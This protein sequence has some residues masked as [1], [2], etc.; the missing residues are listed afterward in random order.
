M[1]VGG[2]RQAEREGE[3]CPESLEKIRNL[4]GAVKDLKSSGEGGGGLEPFGQHPLPYKR[5]SV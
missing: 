3:G 1:S 5:I 4:W 2:G